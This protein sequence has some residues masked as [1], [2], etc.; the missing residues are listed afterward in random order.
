MTADCYRNYIL[1]YT[2]V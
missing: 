1:L 2:P